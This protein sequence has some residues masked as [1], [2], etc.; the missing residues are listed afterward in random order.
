MKVDSLGNLWTSGPGGFRIYSPKG[1]LL[2]KIVLPEVA[3]NLAWG[4]DR[5]QDGLLHGR[6]QYL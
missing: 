4:G 3:A 2:G 5:R 1:Q 6:H